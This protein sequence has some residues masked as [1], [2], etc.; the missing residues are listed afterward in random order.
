MKKKKIKSIMQGLGGIKIIKILKKE[1]N[2][3]NVFNKYNI[4]S[5]FY[6]FLAGFITNLPRF[7]L[8]IIVITFATVTLIFLSLNFSSS[9][10]L[11]KKQVFWFCSF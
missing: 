7:I 10:I 8:E 9:E 3:I 1:N 5:S 2:F 11:L 4:E 6:K